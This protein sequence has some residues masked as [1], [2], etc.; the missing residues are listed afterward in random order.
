MINSNICY[1]KVTK[2]SIALKEAV[3]IDKSDSIN[4]A[5][6]NY[7]EYGFFFIHLFI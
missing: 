3:L 5:C 1:G 4:E 2:L 7:K 6:E